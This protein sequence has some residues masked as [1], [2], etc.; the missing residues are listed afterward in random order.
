MIALCGRQSKAMYMPGFRLIYWC[1]PHGASGKSIIVQ[2]SAAD[3]RRSLC[4]LRF[5]RERNA[6]LK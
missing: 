4:R 1:V 3:N 6:I 2:K 5:F